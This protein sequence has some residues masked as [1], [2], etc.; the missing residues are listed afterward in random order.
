MYPEA[1]GGALPEEA[2]GGAAGDG[3]TPGIASTKK[4]RRQ[5]EGL[6][7]GDGVKA[8]AANGYTPAKMIRCRLIHYIL[9]RMAG[10][11]SDAST[12]THCENCEQ[13]LNQCFWYLRGKVLAF[14]VGF[15]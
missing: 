1:F 2:G 15:G 3:S 14:A 12:E 9:C 5:P 4:R 11:H 6:S 13:T 10:A 7:Q 8:M